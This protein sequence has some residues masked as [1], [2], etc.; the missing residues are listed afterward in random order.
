MKLKQNKIITIMLIAIG[1]GFTSCVNDLNVTPIDP[2]L[3]TEFNQDAAFAKTYAS[4]SLTGQQGAAG[5]G[6]LSNL[7][8]GTTSFIR[9]IWMLNELS[10]DEAICSWGDPGIPELNFN[11]WTSTNPM[12]TGLYARLTVG[13]SYC[14]YFL[15]HTDSLSAESKTVKQR[16]EVRFLRALNYFYLMD[17]FGNP[18]FATTVNKDVLAQ[19]I[20]RADLFVWLEKELKA[21]D[22]KL[23]KFSE[24]STNTYYRVDQP[25]EWLLLSRM[26][27]NAQIYTGT[28]RW[29]DAKIY[30]KKVMDSG[31][32]L[33]PSYAQLFM[34]DNAG[35]F[36]GSTNTA[37]QEIILPIPCDGINTKSWGNS[38]FLIAST[39]TG[40]MAN[41][42]TTEGWGGNRGR[43]A[44]ALKFFPNGIPNGTDLTALTAFAGDKRA[45]LYGWPI[46]DSK[47]TDAISI[48]TTS[49]F[50][51]GLAVSKFSNVR[52][53]G[54]ATSSTQYTDMD[55][56][57]FRL[58][59]AYLTY[60][61]AAYRIN[62]ADP[63]VLPIINQLRDRTSG[64]AP[65]L[66]TIT[67]PK[68]LDEWSREFYFEGRRRMDLIRF[69]CY[70]GSTY[71]WDW[72][73]GSAGGTQF[74]THYNIYPIPA[75]EMQVN[76]NLIQ[77]KDY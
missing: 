1:I 22:D 33:N 51:Q 43:A 3:S 64:N 19:Q 72:K 23:T 63:E 47:S 25:A 48:I 28:A 56:P 66:S 74:D 62:S 17:L 59:E 50:K 67:L 2:N 73:G 68:I 12:V 40:G 61:E 49:I 42:G 37:P 39:H 11:S 20:K 70:G 6:D 31:Y 18:P 57:H 38:L 15:E 71:T 27:L 77:N 55:V 41:W 7:D 29:S 53:D 54:K 8:E 26:Y 45:M 4:L 9:M 65:A 35:T 24:K 36:D 34:A 21:I 52:S 46:S 58:A 10:T 76:P 32:K 30:A 60:A 69:G 44:L 75:S 14:N 16:S 13:I 5:Q